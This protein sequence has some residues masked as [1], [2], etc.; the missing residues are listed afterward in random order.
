P[1]SDARP[2]SS[3]VRK[4]LPTR[5]PLPRRGAAPSSGSGRQDAVNTDGDPPAPPPAPLS[6]LSAEE[7]AADAPSLETLRRVHRALR[8]LPESD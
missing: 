4:P 3:L 2:G 7:L 1:T 6:M 8:A 5:R